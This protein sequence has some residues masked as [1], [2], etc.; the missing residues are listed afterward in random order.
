[1]KWIKKKLFC[2]KIFIKYFSEASW[3]SSVDVLTFA[4]LQHSLHG[5]LPVS[6][7]ADASRAGALTVLRPPALPQVNLVE[8]IH[9]EQSCVTEGT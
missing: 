6:V 4:V 3:A 7:P 8:V 9:H 2:V 1:M 5:T